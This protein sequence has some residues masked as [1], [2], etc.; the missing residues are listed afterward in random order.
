MMAATNCSI[1]PPIFPASL[2]VEARNVGFIVRWPRFKF[3]ICNFLVLGLCVN[4]ITFLTCILHSLNIY[5]NFHLAIKETRFHV[6]WGHLLRAD[7]R[8]KLRNILSHDSSY[9]TRDGLMTQFE[10]MSGR[11]SNSRLQKMLPW[12]PEG[13]FLGGKLQKS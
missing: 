4:V 13:R 8:H 1:Q 11:Q 10:P 12:Y 7:S 6:L 9:Q 2:E 3:Q 5:C